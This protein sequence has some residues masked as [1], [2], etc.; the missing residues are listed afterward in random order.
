MRDVLTCLKNINFK[1]GK[2]YTPTIYGNDV[3]WRVRFFFFFDISFS[4][5]QRSINSER[6]KRERY[7]FLSFLFFFFFFF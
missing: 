5:Y 6:F 1:F 7:F 3:Q 4:S 2:L